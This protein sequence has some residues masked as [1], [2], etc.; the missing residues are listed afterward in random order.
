M[1]V[2]LCSWFHKLSIY[3][4]LVVSGDAACSEHE[5][6][7]LQSIVCK[8]GIVIRNSENPNE[9]FLC[10]AEHTWAA[11]VWPLVSTDTDS[12]SLLHLQAA[13]CARWLCVY[14]LSGW[15]AVPY[16]VIWDWDHGVSL[17]PNRTSEGLLR[18]ALRSPQHFTLS[19]LQMFLAE[20]TGEQPNAS[21]RAKALEQLASH[22]AGS[23]PMY[24]S[25]VLEAESRGKPAKA[26]AL[27]PELTEILLEELSLEERQDY[28]D[29]RTEVSSLSAEE[30]FMFAKRQQWNAWY[31]EKQQEQEV[32]SS[33]I[34]YKSSFVI[35]NVSR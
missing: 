23:D 28:K 3:H 18:F 8:S 27:N 2:K 25:E 19:N 21:S 17:K 35:C 6:A 5:Q 4:G 34:H 29:L 30:K 15:E 9:A 1:L 20:I 24:V 13:G 12:G 31:K 10:L 22:L 16:N 26:Q 32:L 33:V 11:L 14:D 7:G